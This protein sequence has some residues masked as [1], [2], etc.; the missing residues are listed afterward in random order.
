VQAEFDQ[1]AKMRALVGV[2]QDLQPS[3]PQDR[4]LGPLHPDVMC[5]QE[6]KLADDNS[7]ASRFGVRCFCRPT[8]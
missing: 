7:W 4:L 8:K 6:T 2:A 5:L 3:R 1:A